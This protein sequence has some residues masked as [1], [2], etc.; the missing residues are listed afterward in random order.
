MEENILK[1]KKRLV[2]F[3]VLCLS[4]AFASIG[5]VIFVWFLNDSNKE[6]VVENVSNVVL[7]N[8]ENKGKYVTL[9][10]DTLP[11]LMMP[12]SKE[13][14]QFYFVTDV[15][16]QTYIMKLSDETF[17]SIT[18]TI[19]PE[20]GKLTSPYRLTGIT[21]Y[22]N[23][24]V[25]KLAL[26]NSH[27]VFKNQEIN[28]ENFSEYLGV[29]YVKENKVRQ[30]VVAVY[31]IIALFGVFFLV[32][33]FGYIVPALSKVKNGDFGILDEKN[34]IQALEKN[35][36]DG[37][38]M[39][40]GVHG[41]GIETEVKQVFGMCVYDGN[42]LIPH[43]NGTVIEVTK[44]KFSKYDLYVCITQHYLILSECG[45]YKHYYEFND[46]PDLEGTAVEAIKTCISIEEIGTCFPLAEIQDCEIKRVWMGAVHCTITMKNGTSLK[47]M[48]P[49]SGGPGMSHHE[50]YRE[51]ILARLRLI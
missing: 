12:N 19:D 14:N 34:M 27:Y 44:S 22:I 6:E 8:E 1:A 23:E 29:L 5:F 46:R 3:L 15:S 35:I 50:Q 10:I 32:L 9:Q 42:K 20:T 25:K 40:A 33:A 17:I 26:S 7:S 28:A 36:P 38:T 43:E 31:T 47:F 30:R 24:E 4:I 45:K 51:A 37:E 2:T 39:T 13:Q 11:V 49:K 18:D 48:L 16:N 41:V 21:E